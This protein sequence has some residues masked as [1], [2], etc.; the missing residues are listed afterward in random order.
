MKSLCTLLTLWLTMCC[1]SHAQTDTAASTAPSGT[2]ADKSTSSDTKVCSPLVMSKLSEVQKIAAMQAPLNEAVV[3]L[4]SAKIEFSSPALASGKMNY[5]T[6]TPNF[7]DNMAR[8]CIIGYFYLG[9]DQ[10]ATEPLNVDHIEIIKQANP[11][12][13]AA[14]P[15]SSTRIFFR[16]PNPHDLLASQKDIYWKFWK[17]R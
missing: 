10:H 5:V 7:A 14:A 2:Q 3:T 12:D 8:V 13:A 16:A 1:F 9:N 15:V 17:N 11:N 6:I 4:D